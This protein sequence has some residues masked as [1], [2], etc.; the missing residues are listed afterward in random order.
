MVE[1]PVAID[2]G[3][4]TRVSVVP[5]MLLDPR[6]HWFDPGGPRHEDPPHV[7]AHTTGEPIGSG[8]LDEADR[9]LVGVRHRGS[10]G[11]R[12]LS[13]AEESS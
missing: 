3:A 7:V 5:P 8:L 4:I 11:L 12:L 2:G 10:P 13:R 1:G 9:L 6:G